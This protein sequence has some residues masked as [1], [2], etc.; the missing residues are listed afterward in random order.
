MT[1]KPWSRTDWWA[2]SASMLVGLILAIMPHL[3][4]FVQSGSTDYLANIDDNF[5]LLVAR[6]PFYGENSLRGPFSTPAEAIPS[7]YS[8][9]MFV[10]LAKLAHCLGLTSP[11]EI[12]V[13]WRAVGGPLLG[14]SMFVLFRRILASTRFP[15]AFALGC[16]TICLSDD[17]AIE[18]RSLVQMAL[19]VPHLLRGTVPPRN[20]EGLA[21][22]RVVTPLL[23]VPLLIL[24]AASVL[25]PKDRSHWRLMTLGMLCLALCVYLYF[26][27]WT[28]AVVALVGFIGSSLLRWRL[29]GESEARQGHLVD[30][31]TAALVLAG[32]LA[33]GSPQILANSRTFAD[34]GFSPMMERMLRGRPMAPGD[35]AR[36]R[37]LVRPWIWVKLVPGALAVFGLGMGQLE[38]VWWLTASAYALTNSAIVT[39]LEFE[40]F[41]WLFVCELFGEVLILGMIVLGIER[42][43]PPRRRALWAL[44][45][46]PLLFFGFAA[47]WR[48]HHALTSPETLANAH[49]LKTLRPLR[50]DLDDLG[51]DRVLAGPAAARVALLWSRSGLLYH[52]PNTGITEL[53]SNREVN[54]RHALNAWLQG[55]DVEQ[56]RPLARSP[57]YEHGIASTPP[58]LTAE[59]VARDRIALFREIDRDPTPFLDRY[60]PDVL[61]LPRDAPDPERGGPW[62]LIQRTPDW[63]LWETRDTT[64]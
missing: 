63:S 59:G 61:L 45:V 19:Y 54:E 47:V 17:G 57:S 21:I 32:G 46:V 4:W 5:Y 24:L 30:A 51:P 62:K 29:A 26:Y 14:L 27:F 37:Y 10:P 53:Y 39:G 25:G 55:L 43:C 7:L 34:P 44:A 35:P 22:Y 2:C 20:L 49:A 33:L 1:S 23:N 3:V 48:G 40:N 18:G 42:W 15:A 16:A 58:E 6:L 13:L 11:L 31:R 36:S 38:A 64:R 28:A 60:H 50:P 52:Q 56:Y 12:G 8:W 41:H 9:T